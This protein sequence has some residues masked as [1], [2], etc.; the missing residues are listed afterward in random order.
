MSSNE[1]GRSTWRGA[2]AGRGGRGRGGRGRGRGRGWFFG[3]QRS[4][5]R[6]A[7]V[8]TANE[9]KI[10]LPF[11]L[12]DLPNIK[13]DESELLN[14]DMLGPLKKGDCP[15]HNKATIKVINEDSFNAAIMLKDLISSP[16]ALAPASNSSNN[17]NSHISSRPVVL[18]LASDTHPGGG[19][20]T[21]AMAQEEALCYRSS[22]SLSLHK[23][24]Y[25][26][27]ALHGVYTRDVVIIRSSTADGHALLA[28]GIPA[29]DLPVVSVLSIAAVRRPKL[30]DAQT[31]AGDKR[32]VFADA[33]D[34]ALT[35]KKMRLALRMAAA[36][37]HDCLVL[38]ALGCGAFKNPVEE[39]AGAWQ[40][41]LSET[42][43]EGGWWREIW[44]AVLDGADEGN[45]DIF[46]EVLGGMRV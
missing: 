9:T 44:F 13:A 28:P 11:I 45:F 20:Q 26:W 24:Y 22:L 1:R 34:R 8:D 37:G 17:P 39:I 33:D 3:G 38:G 21:G 15:K 40:E 27:D 10:V 14:L 6:Q 36:R 46:E 23:Q 29:A 25:P 7:L 12:K 41:V 18:N 16:N 35:I 32:K 5:A 4:A 19:W 30:A 31:V 43:F 42:E 2:R